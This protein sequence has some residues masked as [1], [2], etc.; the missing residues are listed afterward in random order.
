FIQIEYAPD[1]NQVNIRFT[2]YGCGIEQERIPYLG[3]PFYS[4]KENGIGLGLMI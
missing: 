1:Q 2:D 4:L 3:E